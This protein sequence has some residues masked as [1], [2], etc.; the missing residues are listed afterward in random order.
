MPTRDIKTRFKL[1][2]EQEFKRTMTDAANAVKVLNSEQK[3]AKAQ[4]EATGDAEQYAADQA[5]IL[6]EQIDH[7]KKSVA[8]AE[9]AIKRLTDNGVEKN[10]KQMQTWRTKLNN[11]KTALLNM[12]NRLDKVGTELGE[13]DKAFGDAETAGKDFQTQMEK[14]AT[15]I[16]LQ[17]AISAVD[18]I[19]THIEQIVS[20]AARAAKAMW[21]MGVE[22][23]VWADN[24]ATAANEAGVDVE[25][26]QSWQYA[27]RFIDTSVD[28]IV[29][30]WKDIDSKF[31]AG[32]DTARDYMAVL[33][34]VGI[35]S[36][37]A[38][39][40]M[41]TG[42]EIFWDMI[43]YLHGIGDDAERTSQ[44]ITL[45]GNDWRKL[46]P[47]IAAGSAAYKEMADQG[48]SVAVVSE[49][50]VNAL[51]K[52]ND[53]YEDLSA[54]FTAFK[55]NA[56]AELAPTFNTV[57][58]ALKTA[59]QAMNDFVQSEEGQKALGD[60]NDAL[61]GLIKAFLGED[62]GKG[63]FESIVEGAKTAVKNLTGALE[64]L[65][66]NG[67]TVKKIVMGLGIAWAGLTVTKEVLTFVMLLKSLPL[68]KLS[69]LFSGGKT[70]TQGAAAGGAATGGGAAAGG[71]TGAAKATG[72]V[73]SGAKRAALL[74]GAKD[75]LLG[76]GVETAVV[77][78]AV[79]PA[80]IAEEIDRAN[81]TETM[82]KFRDTATDA[83][84]GMGEEGQKAL[85]IIMAATDGLG[86]S[87]T[88]R[89]IRGKKLMTDLVAIED[90]LKT[91]NQIAEE[92][93]API[94]GGKTKLL[95]K[96]QGLTGGLSMQ[97]ENDLLQRV[98]QETMDYLDNS[99]AVQASGDIGENI[100]DAMDKIL[101]VQEAIDEAPG[102]NIENLYGLIDELVEN[103]DVFDSLSEATQNLLGAYFDTE[104]G[105]GAGST[106]QFNDAQEVLDA[107]FAD[108]DAA[109]DKYIEA[110][111]NLP[112]GLA[113]GMEGTEDVAYTE[114]EEIGKQVDIG[115]A[116]GIYDNA[117]VA[118]EAAN[119]LA[120]W[121]ADA[122]RQVLMVHSPSK[123]FEKIGGYVG[124]GFAMG[125]EESVGAVDRAVGTMMNATMRNRVTGRRTYSESAAAGGADMVNVT[126]V[127]DDEVLGNVMAPIVN[128]K[129][130][131]KINATRR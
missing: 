69:A 58:E 75:I 114:A 34:K 98:V 67:T 35:A 26:Y 123:V 8:A 44:A 24:L 110:G 94:I 56:L 107:I 105:Y 108:L 43:D 10:S 54:Q 20:T 50:N 12:Q 78:A 73:M 2:G 101:E 42:Q 21:D 65:K 130:G 7:Q 125:I 86:I 95:L 109:W 19:K 11:A 45:F 81:I 71:G 63:T 31:A 68:D 111:E 53:E 129:I 127:L 91:I 99:E 47:L 93:E 29:R 3:L 87:E 49:E 60:L 80:L 119:R 55:M 27:S 124:E 113:E 90:D 4:F 128:E 126:M 131:A 30:N 14:V 32:G 100:S 120:G 89:D 16:N 70:L 84:Q 23:S 112:E 85:D 64:W 46:N 66:N 5:R 118:I 121:V 104:S 22:G 79:A 57:A 36:G 18:S 40:Q 102:D 117:D 88:K 74:T 48:R 37:K 92:T 72:K 15:G 28:D 115:V 39:G 51:G 33:A 103:K 59:V 1:E 52:M 38:N 116:N 6:K 9:E 25:T 96:R 76:L 122:S 61:S 62:N 97:A 83:V 17:N 13:E 106:S 41:R 82:Q 77:A